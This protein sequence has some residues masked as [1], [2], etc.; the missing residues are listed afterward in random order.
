VTSDFKELVNA[1][2]AFDPSER[3]TIAEIKCHSWY[4]KDVLMGEGIQFY[5]V[6]LKT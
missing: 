5:Y 6:D 1:M 2:L 4:K 3:L